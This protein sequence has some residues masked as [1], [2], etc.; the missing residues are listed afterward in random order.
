MAKLSLYSRHYSA[1]ELPGAECLSRFCVT[2][3]CRFGCSQ[4][5][6]IGRKQDHTAVFKSD[7]ELTRSP[8]M[9]PF[10]LEQKHPKKTVIVTLLLFYSFYFLSSKPWV[11]YPRFMHCLYALPWRCW[12]IWMPEDLIWQHTCSSNP[13]EKWLLMHLLPQI[14]SKNNIKHPNRATN[15]HSLCHTAETEILRVV[16]STFFSWYCALKMHC[17]HYLNAADTVTV[18]FKC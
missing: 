6:L 17:C 11:N 4:H 5:G 2:E 8:I 1:C 12:E 10:M 16:D 14:G 9:C 7:H 13:Q 15:V 18:N 3:A